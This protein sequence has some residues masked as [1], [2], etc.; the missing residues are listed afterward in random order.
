MICGLLRLLFRFVSAESLPSRAP[1]L[2]SQQRNSANEHNRILE[3]LAARNSILA[4]SS[5]L[6]PAVWNC[7]SRRF[8][9][10]CCTE[11]GYNPS[12]SEATP[13]PAAR[14]S[15]SLSPEAI[16]HDN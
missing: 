16:H 2:F 4:R 15:P 10:S 3:V 6:R 13:L 7:S 1:E 8:R 11:T 14:L 12:P 9:Q 5:G